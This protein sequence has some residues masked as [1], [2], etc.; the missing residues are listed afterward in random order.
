M[1][2]VIAKKALREELSFREFA[3][4]IGV[5]HTAVGNAVRSGRLKTALRKR[6]KRFKVDLAIGTEEW[7]AKTDPL[8]QQEPEDRTGGVPA[9]TK[10]ANTGK[11]QV[12][13][14]G[15]E[16]EAAAA[17]AT[18]APAS[19]SAPAA[20]TNGAAVDT[21]GRALYEARTEQIELGVEEKRLE[22][23]LKRGRLVSKSEVQAM[24]FKAGR[25]AQNAMLLIPNRVAAILAAETDPSAV[26]E[27]LV[28]E[29]TQALES[30]STM[31]APDG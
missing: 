4:R 20:A 6:G 18:A 1:P 22:L 29:I 5:T 16:L 13:L 26:R 25:D 12:G 8:K 15:E 17:A 30:L 27:I 28:R 10:P 23:D 14:Y 31:G 21:K 19:S 2:S 11:R 7:K 24:A 9:G 3:K